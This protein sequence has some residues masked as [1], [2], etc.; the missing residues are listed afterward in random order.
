MI[1]R[2]LVLDKGLVVSSTGSSIVEND[3]KSIISIS[4]VLDTDWCY[5]FYK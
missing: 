1:I 4:L 2:M 3:C 5:N